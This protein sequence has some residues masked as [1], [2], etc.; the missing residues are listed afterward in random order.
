MGTE[1]PSSWNSTQA[2]LTSECQLLISKLRS[3]LKTQS[4]SQISWFSKRLQLRCPQLGHLPAL[5]QAH[6][7]VSG[8]G[9]KMTPQQRPEP[10][11]WHSQVLNH[12]AT[13]ELLQALSFLFT[14]TVI[15]SVFH[16]HGCELFEVRSHHLCFTSYLFKCPRIGGGVSVELNLNDKQEPTLLRSWETV[17]GMII[18]KVMQRPCSQCRSGTM[19]PLVAPPTF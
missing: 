13:R 3:Y 11:Q 17:L 9:V 16:P 7:E 12:W 5:F 15:I 8:S 18:A 10:Q 4:G 2:A 1:N 14:S 19:W 6:V